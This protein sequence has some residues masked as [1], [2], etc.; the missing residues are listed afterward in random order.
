MK[1]AIVL[2]IVRQEE[3]LIIKALES[4]KIPYEIINVNQEP[5]PFNRTLARFNVAIIRP[6]SMYK[7]LYS[8]AVFES[9]DVHAINS[10]QTISI[11]GDKILTYSKLYKNGIPIPDSIIAM[12][13]DA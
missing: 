13:P 12:S 4:Q 9:V 1:V 5:L 11:C 3:K 8:A 7:A 6:I 10:M 2:D